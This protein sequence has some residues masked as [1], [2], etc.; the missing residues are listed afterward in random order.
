VLV[1]W[2]I[3]TKNTTINIDEYN[4][5]DTEAYAIQWDSTYNKLCIL[6]IYSSPW[7]NFTNFLNKFDLI[8]QKLYNI[9][10]CGD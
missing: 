3:E 9:I 8:L 4:V 1:Y 10:I 7:G 2:S 5:D 6:T